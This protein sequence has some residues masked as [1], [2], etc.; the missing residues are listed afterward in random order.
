MTSASIKRRAAMAAALTITGWLAIQVDGQEEEGMV[1]L[2]HST[3]RTPDRSRT[4]ITDAAA[5]RAASQELSSTL[6]WSVL[7]RRARLVQD[8]DSQSADLF[9]PHDWHVTSKLLEPP[10]PPP[11]PVAPEVPF[12]YLGK[13]EDSPQGT[14]FF[15]SENNKVYSV[16]AGQNIDNVWRLDTEDS[17]TLNLTYLP[18]G[19]PQT[20]LKTAKPA[21]PAE[22][23]NQGA[24]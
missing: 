8:Q 13:L 6:N 15:L 12:S 17:S 5:S 14:T 2:A 23:G 24:F 18:L 10:A 11:K 9:K 16:V 22:D 19:Q 21:L 20:L 3:Q 1:Q 7:S 4:A